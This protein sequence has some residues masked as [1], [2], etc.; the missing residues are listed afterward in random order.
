MRKVAE[1][2]CNTWGLLLFEM[3][4]VDLMWT[5]LRPARY[6]T[7][8]AFFHLCSVQH[9]VVLQLSATGSD[10]LWSWCKRTEILWAHLRWKK[11]NRKG[12]TLYVMTYFSFQLDTGASGRFSKA[13]FLR[14]CLCKG[15]F[16]SREANCQVEHRH[17][18]EHASEMLL[19]VCICF[20]FL[21]FFYSVASVFGFVAWRVDARR[22]TML[23]SHPQ[24]FPEKKLS[25]DQRRC[26]FLKRQDRFRCDALHPIIRESRVWFL[27]PP[28]FTLSG[29]ES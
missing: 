24:A 16:F 20:F 1:K 2:A 7:G 4:L 11:R 21:F 29:F 18:S 15:A 6:F 27:S 17:V 28:F 14:N 19:Y 10:V 22:N 9:L 3:S 12:K 13:L 26:K 25:R 23:G 5:L 8:L